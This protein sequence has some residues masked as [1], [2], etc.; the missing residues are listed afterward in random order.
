[1]VGPM[2]IGGVTGWLSAA[3]GFAV[4]RVRERED[5]RR[6]RTESKHGLAE[7]RPMPI[8]LA[9]WPSASVE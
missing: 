2:R 5:V 3:A 7:V 4:S 9:D 6:A 8:S 1:M